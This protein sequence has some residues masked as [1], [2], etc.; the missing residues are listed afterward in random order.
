MSHWCFLLWQ[1]LHTAAESG[2]SRDVHVKVSFG[3]L[4]GTGLE[5][6]DQFIG[7]PFARPPIGPLRWAAPVDWTEPYGGTYRSVTYGAR[8]PQP[9]TDNSRVTTNES[10]L[11]LNLWVPRCT[12]ATAAKPLL[13][14]LYGGSFFAGAGDMY[15]GTELAARTCSVVVTLNYRLGALGFGLFGN[16]G[17]FG[18]LDQQSALRWLQREAGAFGANR[19]QLLLFGQSAGSQSTA[20]HMLLPGSAGLFSAALMQSGVGQTVPEAFARACAAQLVAL[21]NCSTWDRLDCIRRRTWQ[22]VLLAQNALLQV[23]PNGTQWDVPCAFWP[24]VDRTTISQP[25][26]ELMHRGDFHRVPVV[27]GV[28]HDEGNVFAYG[29]WP[30]P[31]AVP[32]FQRMVAKLLDARGRRARPG[33]LHRLVE[34]YIPMAAPGDLR[35]LLG[36]LFGD[37]LFIC[38]SRRFLRQHQRPPVPRSQVAFKFV[39]A[40]RAE[41]DPSPRTWGV[42]HSSELPFVFGV[43][44]SGS[45]MSIP[46][47][48]PQEGKLCDFI[49]A[50]WRNFAIQGDPNI[51]QDGDTAL[52]PPYGEQNDV[53]FEFQNNLG[54]TGHSFHQHQCDAWDAVWDRDYGSAASLRSL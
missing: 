25:A 23:P 5:G 35:P 21:L 9:V 41:H 53:H 40:Q 17:N 38:P 8:C 3:T 52:W 37:F 11:F 54:S 48:T 50:F 32:E 45:I 51:L 4:V 43:G 2:S 14:F 39:F 44:E 13:V 1:L 42:Y 18:L 46:L 49:R 6:V 7:V 30:Q 34:A 36:Q 33:D 22:E 29:D 19:S 47:L 26:D 24:A 10:C 12:S 28:N 31:V 15:N 16:A 27:A 20:L